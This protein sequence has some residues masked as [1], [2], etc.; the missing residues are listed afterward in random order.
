[1]KFGMVSPL[2]R[3]VLCSCVGVAMGVVY[4]IGHTYYIVFTVKN[5][6]NFTEAFVHNCI[7]FYILSKLNKFVTTGG[8]RLT[9]KLPEG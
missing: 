5:D 6:I 8:Q 2:T 7:V 3:R 4:C 9:E 1:M